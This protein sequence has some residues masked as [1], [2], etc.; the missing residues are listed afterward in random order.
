MGNSF[1]RSSKVAFLIQSFNNESGSFVPFMCM[2]SLS[3]FVSISSP[4]LLDETTLISRYRPLC[5]IEPASKTHLLLDNS[6][7]SY[8]H[9]RAHETVLD[10]VCR[11]LLE[12]K[13]K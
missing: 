11:L 5:M 10:L 4:S 9:L 3:F 1:V 8:T 6:P 12:K 13:K 2:M 7:V